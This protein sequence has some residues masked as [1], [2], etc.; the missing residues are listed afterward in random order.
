MQITLNQEEIFHALENYARSQIAI[1]DDQSIEIDLKA[2][3]GEHGYSATLEIKTAGPSQTV[4][5]SVT[6][7]PEPERPAADK[8][9]SKRLSP[10]TE[11]ETEE[12]SPEKPT[13]KEPSPSAKSIFAKAE[14]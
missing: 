9:L 12:K 1:R 14:G 3:R 2:G 10:V 11:T 7:A 6:P 5:A 13:A 8:P 4:T